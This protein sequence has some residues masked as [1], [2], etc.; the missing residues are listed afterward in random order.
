MKFGNDLREIPADIIADLST[1]QKYLYQIVKMISTGNLDQDV[2]KQMIR[3][4]NHSRWLT[5]ARRLC[6]LWVW[7]HN[8]RRNSLI[9]KNLKTIIFYIISVYAVMWFEIKCKPNILLG[10]SHL[11]RTIQLVQ[12]YCPDKVKLVVREVIQGV[13][14]MAT[15]K[16]CCLP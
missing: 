15:L 8:L 2:L 3:P 16:T 9:Y 7:K 6:R 10:T 13:D 11:L 1:D 5:T 12:M 4:L 14:G